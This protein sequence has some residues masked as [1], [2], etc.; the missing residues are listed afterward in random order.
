MDIYFMGN[1]VKEEA[2]N[3]ELHVKL[4]SKCGKGHFM[5]YNKNANILTCEMCNEELSLPKVRKLKIFQR[6]K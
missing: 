2:A 1:Y 6:L 5:K 3:K 4:L